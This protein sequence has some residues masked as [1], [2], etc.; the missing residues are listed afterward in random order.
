MRF[1]RAAGGSKGGRDALVKASGGWAAL[2]SGS[3]YA[4]SLARRR[5]RRDA[6]VKASGVRAH[7]PRAR[8]VLHLLRG[9]GG[10]EREGRAGKSERRMGGP[11]LGLAVCSISCAAGGRKGGRDALVKASG[12][13]AARAA[14]REPGLAVP[15]YAAQGSPRALGGGVSLSGT[16]SPTRLRHAR[17]SAGQGSGL[18]LSGRVSPSRLRRAR[19]S[20]GQGCEPSWVHREHGHRLQWISS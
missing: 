15:V 18:S 9:G 17:R 6:L 10:G 14:G 16:V 2:A 12:G 7:R 3:W 8:G 5:V 13:W 11:G 4:A 1:V 20:A 19:R